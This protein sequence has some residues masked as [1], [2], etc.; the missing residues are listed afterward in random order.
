MA[1]KLDQIIVIDIESTCWPGSPPPGQES[2][3]I[4]IGLCLL[5]VASGE[6]VARE[7]I[8]VKPER[9]TV[10]PFCTELTTLTQAQV[11]TGISFKAAC[12]L[13][14]DKYLSKERT[15]ASFGDYDRRQVDRQCQA[16]KINYPFGPTHLNIKNLLALMLGLPHEVGLPRALELLELPLVGVHHRGGDDAWNIAH[17][18]GALLRR[19]R[20]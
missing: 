2:E 9:S 20:P 3:I 4:E 8:L 13:L 15:W 11:E 14:K 18:L 1:R 12:D 16:R 6:R 7:S 19:G 17:L 10:S 5:E